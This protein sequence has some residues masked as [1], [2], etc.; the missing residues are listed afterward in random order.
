MSFKEIYL[1]V[2]R[3]KEV[4]I[5]QGRVLQENDLEI[6]KEVIKFRD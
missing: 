1:Q 2:N 4:L 5:N 3:N 6:K